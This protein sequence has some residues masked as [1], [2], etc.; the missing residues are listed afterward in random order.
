MKITRAVA[1]STLFALGL[2]AFAQNETSTPHDPIDSNRV[3]LHLEPGTSGTWFASTRNL[4]YVRAFYSD[5]NI[6]I[7]ILPTVKDA[8]ARLP[9]LIEDLQ[10]I[11]GFNDQ[12][13]FLEHDGLVANDTYFNRNSAY[14][15]FIG[16]WHLDNQWVSGRDVNVL[17]TWSRGITGRGVP[18][19]AVD[20]G[21]QGNHPDLAPNFDSA[22]SWNFA[23]GNANPNPVSSGD[24]HGTPV[25]GIIAGRGGNNLGSTGAAPLGSLVGLRISYGSTFISNSADAIR[26]R[27][28]AEH[29]DIKVKNHSY[30][31]NSAF[32]T[33]PLEV[34]A[35]ADSVA[36]G[37]IHVWSAG[38]R[39]GAMDE[40]ANKVP[41]KSIPNGIIVAA[42][43]A[44]GTFSSYS[45]FGASVTC[46]TPSSGTEG[47][48]IV[49]TD[50]T[51]AAG[52]NNGSNQQLTDADYTMTFGGTSAAAPLAAGVLTL[53]KQIQP[54]LDTRFAKHLIARTSRLVDAS[55]NTVTS[56]GGWKTNS[57]GF[58]FNQN[59]GFGLLDAEALTREAVRW[60]KPTPL[61]VL[62]GNINVGAQIPDNNPNGITR[63]FSLVN[64][65][66][67]EELVLTFD[68]THPR[69]NEIE[70]EV[71]SPTGTTARVIRRFFSATQ[72]GGAN[73]NNLFTVNTF[74]GEEAQ[75]IWTIRVIDT[76]ADNTGT[77]N[78]YQV[79]VRTGSL[80]PAK[81][82]LYSVQN[83]ASG[84]TYMWSVSPD[85]PESSQFIAAPG[86]SDWRASAVADF[87]ND[88]NADL[89]W[90]NIST[91]SVVVWLLD[92]NRAVTSIHFLG[93]APA[94]WSLVGAGDSTGNDRPDLLWVNQSAG[95]LSQWLMS[96]N[97]VVTGSRFLGGFSAGW[98]PRVFSEMDWTPGADIVWQNTGNGSTVLWSL[99]T[100]GA[101]TGS[102]L[103]GTVSGPW[104]L[105]AGGETFPF[106]RG[107]LFQNSAN[108]DIAH[109]EVS[110]ERQVVETSII[111]SG[112]SVWIFKGIGR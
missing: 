72:P 101:V 58:K 23:N 53:V 6:H 46:T 71:T 82:S 35:M 77:W 21:I 67:M 1:L 8:Q 31:I 96:E 106:R 4:T 109:W 110:P 84:D 17:P 25:A 99:N 45:R 3:V 80:M 104:Q 76:L 54:R 15:G 12:I 2:C 91:G 100:N 13:V 65:Y 63:Q 33:S 56:D 83:A 48:G 60:E 30:S 41:N 32:A 26:W 18:T 40:D 9:R 62:S 5:P 29:R 95:L 27:S 108:G 92:E 16:H 89:L 44:N 24:N 28:S 73:I 74:W 36:N 86:T 112:L 37:T 85:G 43:N 38:N 70:I 79:Q 66:K 19:A 34:A 51:G 57:A 14:Q 111:A 55:D 93:N 105:V 11:S 50:R 68:I 107:L 49:A 81:P 78:S 102:Y 10:V 39:R 87:N 90:H 97:I 64:S 69:R 88:G 75:G 59:Y 20:D 42:L 47:F 94:G 52:Y 103:F 61:V 7:F 22:L 98:E